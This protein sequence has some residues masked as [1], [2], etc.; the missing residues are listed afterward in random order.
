[1]IS[2][3]SFEP[4][5][6]TAPEPRAAG[7]IDESLGLLLPLRFPPGMLCLDNVPP[8]FGAVINH[9]WPLGLEWS[10]ETDDKLGGWRFSGMFKQHGESSGFWA[11]VV[12]ESASTGMHLH[13]RGGAY[14]ECIITLAGEL[15]DL[16]DDRKPVTLRRGDVMFHAPYTIHDPSAPQFWVGLWHQPRGSLPV[17]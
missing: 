12:L 7:E 14:G 15:H 5:V 16:R 10:G 6:V 4:S 2:E 3:F 8:D 11:I 17:T 13:N 9:F 1:M